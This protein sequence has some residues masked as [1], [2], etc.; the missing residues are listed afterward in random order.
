MASVDVDRTS[1]ALLASGA[2]APP[3]FICVVL[4]EGAVPAI[5]PV[6]YSPLRHPVSTFAIGEFGWIQVANFLLTG[7]LLVGFA[8]GL[9]PALRR[10]GGG[11]GI[12]LLFGLIAVGFIG[13]GLFTAD[14]MNGYPPGTPAM[15]EGTTRTLHGILHD[16]FSSLV[17]LGLPAACV[18]VGYRFAR[19]GHRW[20]AG[21]S[22]GTAVVF[23]TGFILAAMGF[24]QNP[25]FVSIAGLLQRFTLIAGLSWIT[26]LALHLLH[27]S[28]EAP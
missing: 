17:F 16:A 25:A 19:S 20:W 12:Q 8:M 1:R 11:L 23:L 27:R 15:P 22:L 21:Y 28:P 18:A 24:A 6:G 10:H 3:L 13:A 2:I 7:V 4:I 26:A 5:R 14:P 9:G